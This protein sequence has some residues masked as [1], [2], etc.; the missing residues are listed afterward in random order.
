[1]PTIGIHILKITN[2]SLLYEPRC[3]ITIQRFRIYVA[4]RR[5]VFSFDRKSREDGVLGSQD[6]T[7]THANYLN[8]GVLKLLT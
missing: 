4:I 2:V 5:V 6:S 8:I 1:V 3:R 7:T